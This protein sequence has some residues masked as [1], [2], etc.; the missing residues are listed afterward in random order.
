MIVGASLIN[1][2][3]MIKNLLLIAY[4][5]LK[6][7][8]GYTLLN[9]LGLSAGLTCFAF[10]AVW[11]KDELSYDRFNDKAERIVRIVGKVTTE[12]ESFDHA[13]SSVP[14]AKALQEDF[15]EVMN[16]VRIDKNDAIIVRYGG[17][18]FYEDKILLTDPSFFDVFSYKLSEGDEKT[19]LNEPY[20][21]ILTQS[22][23][24]KY[25]GNENPLGKSLMI[26]LYDSTRKGALY[27]I[28]GVIPDPPKNAHFDFNFL[29]SFKTLEYSDKESTIE[30]GWGNNGY[31]TYILLKDKNGIK[32]LES[33]LP[34]FTERHMGKKMKE[35][36]MRYDFTLQPLTSIH[37][38]SN[39]RY[40]IEPTG[41]M[42]NVFIFSTIGIFILLIA[43][44][45]YMNL[46][47]ARSARRAKE[48]G[49]KKVLGAGKAEL[50]LQ[51]LVEAIIVS[52]V[53]LFVSFL[54]CQLLQPVMEQLTG[55][56]ISIFSE[57]G[58]LFFLAG[59]AVLLGLGSGLYPAFF[60]TAYK[61]VNVLKGSMQ[62]PYGGVWL[63]KALVI[64][65]FTISVVLIAGILVV[66]SQLS[67]IQHK[68]LGYKKD[69]LLALKF[70]G[71]GDLVKNFIAF[72]NAVLSNPLISGVTTSNSLLGFG[73]GNSGATTVNGEGKSITTSIYRLKV[74]QDYVNVHGMKIIAGRNFSENIMSDTISYIL[75]E[76]AVKS[77]GWVNPQNAINKPFS[78]GGHEG[79]VIGIIK[80]FNF[81]SLQH[82]VEPLVILPR[83]PTNGFSQITMRI[84]MNKPKE[85][86]K[87]VEENWKKYF[88]DYNLEYNFIDKKLQEQYKSEE[89]FAKL[90]LYFSV[91]SLL[92][93][94]LGLFGL[95][96]FA[97]QQRTKEIGI[98][99]VLG[100]S[101]KG[102]V[103][104]ISK[105]F[106]KLVFIA[107]FIAF[108]LSW[109]V[110]NKWLDDFA[111]RIHIGWWVFA[112][113]GCIALTIALLTVSGQAIKA[114]ISNPVKSLRNP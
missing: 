90:F 105:D 33:K 26:L 60:L 29:A 34:A 4:R 40:E 48:V 84:D 24:K 42:Q 41:N 32:T 61:P 97:T 73:L 94:C 50:V 44:I 95:A 55:K 111:Y 93:A 52:L 58:I 37:L 85:V 10:I 7:S 21:I 30:E 69:A 12:A 53:S 76:A 86:L 46:A 11:V 77:L 83:M 9:I 88:P 110:M 75:N 103:A 87:L 98:R 6:K 79:K 65:Q 14:M 102:I 23:A 66:N 109:L 5:S 28:T 91:L 64:T 2:N 82:A 38:H 62:S 13:V 104:L 1:K 81:N 36:K 74:D 78:M 49:V 59:I 107:S 114:A 108:P 67:Y 18:Q 112:V 92:I 35:W 16:T 99:K 57:K 17:K 56:S 71:S 39:R 96:A 15:P 20:N 68:D 47:T 63:R 25:F 22:M 19:A 51:Y 80:N 45:N 72:K 106:L 100:A 101:V 113:A 27:K 89:R 31:Y 70:N 8:K 43:A 54:F 3:T